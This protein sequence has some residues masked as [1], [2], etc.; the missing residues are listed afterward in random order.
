M[1]KISLFNIWCWENWTAI[2]KRMKLDHHFTSN[3]KNN[4]KWITDLNVR[5]ETIK[6]LEEN[7][8]STHLDISLSNVTL[9][10]SPL[11]KETKAKINR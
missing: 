11:A 8:S 10:M 1:G 2:C 3:T 7:I 4:S 6:I 9:D 5:L